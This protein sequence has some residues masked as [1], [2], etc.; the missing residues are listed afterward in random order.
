[1]E[2]AQRKHLVQ[3]SKSFFDQLAGIEA[4]LLENTPIDETTR[5]LVSREDGPGTGLPKGWWEYTARI[6]RI[7]QGLSERNTWTA[8]SN[9]TDNV[10]ELS[11]QW[12]V[13]S[14]ERA[15]GDHLYRIRD[16]FSKTNHVLFALGLDQM[17]SFEHRNFLALLI[18]N[19][20]CLQ[21]L[22]PLHA[23]QF[24][25]EDFSRYCMFIDQDLFHEEGLQGI[26]KKRYAQILFLNVITP[27]PTRR[28][29]WTT[30]D[31]PKQLQHWHLRFPGISL[32]KNSSPYILRASSEEELIEAAK[33][34]DADI[35]GFIDSVP[36]K[37]VYALESAQVDLPWGADGAEMP[38]YPRPEKDELICFQDLLDDK[39]LFNIKDD[40]ETF[41]V[42]RDIA[43]DDRATQAGPMNISMF[44]Q[45]LFLKQ[46]QEAGIAVMNGLLYLLKCRGGRMLPV[47]VYS[48][49][50][51]ILL[52]EIAMTPQE[53]EAF[54]EQLHAFVFRHL[55]L[56]GFCQADSRPKGEDRKTGSYSIKATRL[57]NVLVSSK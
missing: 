54:R 37:M 33:V 38:P 32:S 39:T 20:A 11:P 45:S 41:Q 5:Q 1:M 26:M 10:K 17:R 15:L 23:F 57:L 44:L 31:P 29:W 40:H 56:N 13:I 12:A 7:A 30:I 50:L 18:D 4:S 21:A 43:G 48:E 42:M 19:G 55:C 14:I 46:F 22:G 53:P 52:K 49:E 28:L 2:Q 3:T 6:F 34:I 9:S 51:L 35:V 25:L 16:Q 24:S 8:G 47:T 36:F 27:H